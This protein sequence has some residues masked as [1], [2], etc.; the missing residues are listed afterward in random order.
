MT[1][2]WKEQLSRI[3]KN[4][5]KNITVCVSPSE[6]NYAIGY[7]STNKKYLQEHFNN[8]KFV[9]D[10]TLKGREFTVVLS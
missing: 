3:E 5:Q 8:I 6:I 4:G 1:E 7:N 2:I 10:Q 9:K